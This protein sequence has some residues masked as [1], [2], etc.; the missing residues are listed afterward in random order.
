[1]ERRRVTLTYRDDA[2]KVDH[3]LLHRANETRLEIEDTRP[4]GAHLGPVRARDRSRTDAA[5]VASPV[6]AFRDHAH[7]STY[8]FSDLHT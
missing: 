4:L 1:M 2:G 5:V 8:V 7:A 3:E 6:D